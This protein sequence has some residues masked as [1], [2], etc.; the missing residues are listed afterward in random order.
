MTAAKTAAAV[1]K[2]KPK[3]R[4]RGR[5]AVPK[6]RKRVCVQLTLAPAEIQI[7]DQW[8]ERNG[9]GTKSLHVG[10]AIRYAERMG[11][12]NDEKGLLTQ[13][14]APARPGLEDAVGQ[15]L[16]ALIP[17]LIQS[18]MKQDGLAWRRSPP[19]ISR[20]LRTP[21]RRSRVSKW[22]APPRKKEKPMAPPIVT[23]VYQI[24]KNATKSIAAQMA[25]FSSLVLYVNP[26]PGGTGELDFLQLEVLP[27]GDVT[28]DTGPGNPA[29]PFQRTIVLHETVPGFVNAFGPSENPV[30]WQLQ[31]LWQNTISQKLATNCV[32]P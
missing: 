24:P 18:A 25:E 32:I 2:A 17:R 30:S 15:H 11:L 4:E 12:F 21:P 1:S 9:E 23:L 22:R 5:P 7:L 14:H 8:V 3:K 20:S 27:G 13:P 10:M 28:I 29:A 31:T 6:A 16:A 26:T 19:T